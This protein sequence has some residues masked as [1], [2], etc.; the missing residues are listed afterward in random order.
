MDLIP[1]KWRRSSLTEPIEIR[2]RILLVEA[3]SGRA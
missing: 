3:E 1:T 2:G